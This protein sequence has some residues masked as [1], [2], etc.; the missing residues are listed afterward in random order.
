MFR[1]PVREFAE[2]ARAEGV[3]VTLDEGEHLPH[4]A[5]AFGDFFPP[6]REAA[7]RLGEAVRRLAAGAGRAETPAKSA[8]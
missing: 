7:V 6:A 2:K 1:D 5:T 8:G 3:S 4:V